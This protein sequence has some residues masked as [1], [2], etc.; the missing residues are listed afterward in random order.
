MSRIAWLLIPFVLVGCQTTPVATVPKVVTQEVDKYVPLPAA[1]TA[2][3]GK[4]QPTD[5][6][7]GEVRRVAAVRGNELDDCNQRMST[8]R[9]AQPGQH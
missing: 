3:C 8:I 1:L 7:W 9:N 5:T 4:E 2:D 6:T